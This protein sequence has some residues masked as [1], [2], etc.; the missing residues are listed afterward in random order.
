MSVLCHLCWSLPSVYF[1]LSDC[2]FLILQLLAFSEDSPTYHAW[3][4]PPVT[5]KTKLYF[6]NLTNKEEFLNGTAKPKLQEVGPYV[7]GWVQY[8]WLNVKRMHYILIPHSLCSYS[9]F[10]VIFN[11]KAAW[12]RVVC[13][14][15]SAHVELLTA[16]VSPQTDTFV[17][18]I[19]NNSRPD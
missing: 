6:F 10:R 12:V 19:I 4:E 3:K 7:L 1:S 11:H 2:R 17:L 8:V 9:G 18:F 14:Y 15:S 13:W 5:I 16:I